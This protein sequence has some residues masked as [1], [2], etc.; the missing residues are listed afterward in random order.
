MST[1]NPRRLVLSLIAFMGMG[2]IGGYIMRGKSQAVRQEIVVTPAT[3]E[4]SECSDV[5]ESK[6][7]ECRR[8][9]LRASAP[10]QEGTTIVERQPSDMFRRRSKQAP[11]VLTSPEKDEVV[12]EP[13]PPDRKRY[14]PYLPYRDYKKY[15]LY[16]AYMSDNQSKVGTA[17]DCE[18]TPNARECVGTAAHCKNVPQ[19]DKCVGT[20]YYCATYPTEDVCRG[21]KLGCARD[22]RDHSCEGTAIFCEDKRFT[23]VVDC[24][25]TEAYCE[26][27][28]A[29]GQFCFGTLAFCGL[30]PYEAVCDADEA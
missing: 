24:R 27:Q 9:L 25:G 3:P 28:K 7:D 26:R 10:H 17:T 18:I 20:E 11:V 5:F 15:R 4:K 12:A 23:D 1:Q 29:S 16:K 30:H 6:Y 22:Y 2:V 14:A 13:T 8:E 21:T 19:D